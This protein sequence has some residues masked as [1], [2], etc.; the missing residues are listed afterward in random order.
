MFDDWGISD[1]VIAALA[2]VGIMFVCVF[3]LGLVG[4]YSKTDA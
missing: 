3:M 1:F 4:Y 2:G